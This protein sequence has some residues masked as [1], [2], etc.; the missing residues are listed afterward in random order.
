MFPQYFKDI[1]E[2]SHMLRHHLTFHHHIIYIDLNALTQLRL[3]HSGHHLLIGRPCVFQTKRHH[4][5][6]VV[7]NGSDKNYLF[8][9][10]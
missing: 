7:S 8:L 6:M 4:L 2:V 10:V 1:S 3:E 5:I 9:V